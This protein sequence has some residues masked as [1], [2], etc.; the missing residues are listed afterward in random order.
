[1]IWQRN[2][3]GWLLELGHG[4]VHWN[5]P[6]CPSLW[7]GWMGRRAWHVTVLA[8]WGDEDE[9]DTEAGA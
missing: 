9:D 5:A 7:V 4:Y 2:R 8:G 3:H 6:P 1:M